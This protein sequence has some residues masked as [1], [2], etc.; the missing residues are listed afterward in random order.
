MPHLPLYGKINSISSSGSHLLT[1]LCFDL[2]SNT[3]IAHIINLQKVFGAS[4]QLDREQAVT[5]HTLNSPGVQSLSSKNNQYIITESEVLKYS[6]G[7]FVSIKDGLSNISLSECMYNGNIILVQEEQVSILTPNGAL[8]QTIELRAEATSMAISEDNRTLAFGFIDGFVEVFKQEH[9]G[10]QPVKKDGA[11]GANPLVMHKNAAVTSL[12]IVRYDDNREW[13]FSFGEDRKAMQAHTEELIASERASTGLHQGLVK[14]VISSSALERLHT[15]SHDG[16]AKSW[17]RSNTKTRPATESVIKNVTSAAFVRFDM[18]D[19]KRQMMQKRNFLVVSGGSKADGTLEFWSFADDDSGKLAKKELQITTG[20]AWFDG[21]YKNEKEETRRHV[22]D[23]IGNWGIRFLD[24]L[25]NIAK[26]KGEDEKVRIHAVD[27]I[28]NTGL[29]AAKY[30]LEKV[31]KSSPNR[32]TRVAALDHYAK[33]DSTVAPLELGLS[34]N[35]KEVFSKTLGL[36][37]ERSKE[38]NEARTLLEQAVTRTS[39]KEAERDIARQ[40]IDTLYGLDNEVEALLLGVDNPLLEQYAMEEVYRKGH[41]GD[42]KAQSHF[43]LLLQDDNAKT[44]QRAQDI[45]FLKYPALA[46]FARSRDESLHHRLCNIEAKGKSYPEQPSKTE[47]SSVSTEAKDLVNQL[48]AAPHPD[49]SSYATRLS[50]SLGSNDT[51]APLLIFMSSDDAQVRT[52]AIHG[53]VNVVHDYA[54]SGLTK[55]F[56]TDEVS[57]IRQLAF[58]GVE[59]SVQ[60]YRN[61]LA[62][63]YQDIRKKALDGLSNFLEEE[64]T[65]E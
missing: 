36:L 25:V 33:V 32:K 13:M 65:T 60:K 9:S 37:G 17:V 49:L 4:S 59:K 11:R 38:N 46:T 58:D 56:C 52:N 51:L 7:A 54:N 16:E 48:M 55:A 34:N 15:I 18:K 20:M 22:I 21:F 39:W 42:S 19:T 3:H 30:K 53:L 44:R 29:A 26:R 23:T 64:V 47:A 61:A 35:C 45:L 10:F 63:R 43:K 28:Y 31:V 6:D 27:T 2:E 24:S 1:T 8:A 12:A 57:T 40:A 50:T 41:L 14:A 62:S 5:S